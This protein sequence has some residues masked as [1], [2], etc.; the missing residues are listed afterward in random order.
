VVTGVQTCALPILFDAYARFAVNRTRYNHLSIDTL[1]GTRSSDKVFIF[2]SGRSLLE[3]GESEWRH[4]EEHNTLGF[5]GFIYQKWV[6]VDYH[7]IRGW[8]EAAEGCIEWRN[9]TEKF[10]NTLNNNR[11]FDKAILILQADYRAFFTN[12]LVGYKYLPPGKDVFFYKTARWKGLPSQS[13][14]RGLRHSVGTLCDA[15]NFA[16]L[17]GYKEIVLV[18]VDLY[19]TCYFW[20][21]PDMTENYD[22]KVKDMVASKVSLRGR[23][24]NESHSTVTNG[25]IE[26]LR[27][28]DG[29][30][31]RHG[32]RMSIYNP[33]SL[34]NVFLP[35]YKSDRYSEKD[36]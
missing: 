27:E 12:R 28:W 36:K 15:I 3:I 5:T 17:M 10:I 35:V 21:P 9:Y 14:R 13:L 33:R 11:L 20:L 2:G 23:M 24:Y 6:R 8:I 7:L 18:G 4:F 31:L 32:V 34:L 25:I 30:F 16:F 19:D 22:H 1:L 26:Q 29:F